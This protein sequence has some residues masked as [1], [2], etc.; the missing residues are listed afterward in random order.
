MR[1]YLYTLD[2]EAVLRAEMDRMK[3]DAS[4]RVLNIACEY[5]LLPPFLTKIVS[6]ENVYGVEINREIVKKVPNIKYC[7]VDADRF[8]FDDNSFD[9]VLSIWG[10]EHFQTTNIFREA[11]R[12]LKPGRRMIF[13]TPNLACPIFWVSKYFGEK[14]GA[15]YYKRILRSAYKP[16]QAY[17]RFN[18]TGAV[19]RLAK[20]AG[21]NIANLLYIGPAVA[22][23]YF[24]FSKPIQKF[25]SWFEKYFLT[26]RIL[27]RFKPYLVVVLEK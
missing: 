8:P 17:Y 26:N 20:E 9:L 22:V 1:Q 23:W 27:F 19:K 6:P 21:L 15:F 2:Y 5:D 12:V 13:I 24:S 7:D 18:T 11:A 3:L 10:V 25:V 14:I 16:H 4:S